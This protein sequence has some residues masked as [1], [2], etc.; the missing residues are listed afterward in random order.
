AAGGARAGGDRGGR[1][2]DGDVVLSRGA[3]HRPSLVA[4]RRVARARGRTRAADPAW[5]IQRLAADVAGGARGRELRRRQLRAWAHAPGRGRRGRDRGR[6]RRPRGAGPGGAGP[7]GGAGPVRH[8]DE[9]A[10]GRL[11][12][13]GRGSGAG[14]HVVKV[15]GRINSINVQKVMWAIAELGV[16][17]E[18]ID[19]GRQFGVVDTV[20]YRR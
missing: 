10:A 15:W 8:G 2:D 11:R 18:R 13:R 3:G 9:G 7:G 1:S 6:P 14:A 20:E 16:P 5:W 19:A 12:L 4:R 17:C